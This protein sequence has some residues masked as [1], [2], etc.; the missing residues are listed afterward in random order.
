MTQ[1]VMFQSTPE[2]EEVIRVGYIVDLTPNKVY[3]LIETYPNELLVDDC[4]I[5]LNVVTT[6][7]RFN[8]LHLHDLAQ[9]QYCDADGNIL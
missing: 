5:E 9:W 3:K 2:V 4:G 1:Y 8:C 7:W 6:D